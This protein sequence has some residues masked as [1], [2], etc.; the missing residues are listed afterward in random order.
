[1]YN[2]IGKHRKQKKNITLQRL[3]DSPKIFILNG[4]IIVRGP[5]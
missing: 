3:Y 4:Y 5:Y 1:M 2:Q